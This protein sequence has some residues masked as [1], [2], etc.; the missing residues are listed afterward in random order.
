MQRLQPRD[1]LFGLRSDFD[2][3]NHRPAPVGMMGGRARKNEGAPAGLSWPQK[4]P[5]A[6]GE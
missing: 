3:G 4:N 6:F 2:P 1:H 5:R